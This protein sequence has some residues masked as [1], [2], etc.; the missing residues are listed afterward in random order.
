MSWTPAEVWRL[1]WAAFVAGYHSARGGARLDAAMLDTSANVEST[2]VEDREAAHEQ[3]RQAMDRYGFTE[4]DRRHQA[5][6]ES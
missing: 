5:G 6:R 4:R 2:F 1:F 3:L